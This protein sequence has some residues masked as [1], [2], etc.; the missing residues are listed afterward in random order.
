MS[1][2]GEEL[3]LPNKPSGFGVH[4]GSTVTVVFSMFVKLKVEKDA[5]F[6]CSSEDTLSSIHKYLNYL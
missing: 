2:G 1:C 3:I 6:H 5:C 4:R